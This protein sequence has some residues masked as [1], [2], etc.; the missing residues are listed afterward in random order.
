MWISSSFTISE[1]LPCMYSPLGQGA[2]FSHSS[3]LVS[4]LE[5]VRGRCEF[6]FVIAISCCPRRF[7]F[8]L[9]DFSCLFHS[10]SSLQ[11]PFCLCSSFYPLPFLTAGVADLSWLQAQDQ[12]QRQ[13]PTPAAPAASPVTQGLTPIINSSLSPILVLLLL[14]NPS[15][16]TLL[17]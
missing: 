8:V 1:Y 9:V 10:S 15:W 4:R 12:M 6:Q 17:F 7:Q 5:L 16:Y 3:P 14:C 2:G 13:Q 11:V